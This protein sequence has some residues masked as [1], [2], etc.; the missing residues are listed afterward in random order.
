MK[1]KRY[2][3]NYILACMEPGKNFTVDLVNDIEEKFGVR[4]SVRRIGAH[5][6]LMEASG[7]VTSEREIVAGCVN[8][9]AWFKNYG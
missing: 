2:I 4:Y 3:K 1:A 6:R 7:E 8:R 9:N 5:L